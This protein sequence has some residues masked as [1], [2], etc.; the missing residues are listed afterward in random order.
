MTGLSQI[1]LKAAPQLLNRWDLN[2]D[3]CLAFD[4]LP[5]TAVAGPLS[6]LTVAWFHADGTLVAGAD[7]VSTPITLNWLTALQS[8]DQSKD[9]T[10][11]LKWLDRH[12]LRLTLPKATVT[13]PLGQSSVQRIIGAQ[14]YLLGEINMARGDRAS[15]DSSA[16]QADPNLEWQAPFVSVADRDR[17][18]QLNESELQSVID[19]LA[20]GA[21]SQV[22]LMVMFRGHKLFDH[23]DTNADNQLDLRELNAASRLRSI[24]G[25]GDPPDSEPL[26]QSDLPLSI[27]VKLHR[28]PIP[29]YSRFAQIPA[30]VVQAKMVATILPKT[31]CI[32]D[33]RRNPTNP[34]GVNNQGYRWSF[35]AATNRSTT[36]RSSRTRSPHD[37]T[38]TMVHR[39]GSQS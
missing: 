14:Q 5:S 18:K 31:H 3:E 2:E 26:G 15:L 19:L 33:V 16:I 8:P 20:D 27:T 38:S 11:K 29:A 6:I 13:I 7:T 10:S 35:R 17:D 37:G 24:P 9:L 1:E 30:E 23:L 34:R 36:I 21:A 32:W 39:H 28:G 22:N 4:E 25:D 12:R